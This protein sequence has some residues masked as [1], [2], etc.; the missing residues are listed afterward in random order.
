MLVWHRMIPPFGGI[1]QG[2]MYF[3][4]SR[5]MIIFGWFLYPIGFSGLV[6][7]FC[8]SIACMGKFSTAF[9]LEILDV[10]ST[11]WH[12]ITCG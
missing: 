9:D 5:M 12:S 6:L 7:H 11:I 3:R 1:L 10:T 4:T 8:I 2:L